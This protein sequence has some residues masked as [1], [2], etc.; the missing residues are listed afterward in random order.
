MSSPH[1]RIDIDRFARVTDL[2]V[3]TAYSILATGRTRISI[4]LLSRAEPTLT[5]ESLA[6]G[7]ARLDGVSLERARVSLVHE[8]L[9]KLED[10]GVL[11]YELQGEELSVDGPIV[12]LENPLGVVVETVETP[13]RTGVDR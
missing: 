11:S 6:S 1:I 5:L 10:Y 7:M 13:A 9:P 2:S 8:I 4:Y 12:G 3:E